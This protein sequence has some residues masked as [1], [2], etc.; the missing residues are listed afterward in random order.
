MTL[1]FLALNRLKGHNRFQKRNSEKNYE[2]FIVENHPHPLST[3]SCFKVN[4]KTAASLKWRSITQTC[5]TEFQVAETPCNEITT[6]TLPGW[7]ITISR[8]VCNSLAGFQRAAEFLWMVLN[9]TLWRIAWLTVSR[10]A[11]ATWL[12]FHFDASEDSNSETASD[13]ACES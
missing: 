4:A 10:K 2:S 9:L 11:R 7:K 3:H 8:S 5:G 1:P 13:G 6:W 12:H